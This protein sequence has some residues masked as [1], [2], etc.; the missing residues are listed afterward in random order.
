MTNYRAVVKVN[1]TFYCSCQWKLQASMMADCQPTATWSCVDTCIHIDVLSETSLCTELGMWFWAGT[2]LSCLSLRCYDFEW[3]CTGDCIWLYFLDLVCW[4]EHAQRLIFQIAC[5]DVD[6]H[7]KNHYKIVIVCWFL[8]KSMI[9][10]YTYVKQGTFLMIWLKLAFFVISSGSYNLKMLMFVINI[11]RR[12][13]WKRRWT[14]LC[15]TFI[16][17]CWCKYFIGNIW[18]VTMCRHCHS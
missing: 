6:I 11:C 1:G 16:L 8:C 18:Q 12:L 17:S 13:V 4:V 2:F 15:F 14:Q 5:V 10:M 3:T 9:A 7:C